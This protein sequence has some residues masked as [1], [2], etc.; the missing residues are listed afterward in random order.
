[1]TDERNSWISQ[2]VAEELLSEAVERAVLGAE[3]SDDSTT[4]VEM[5]A[6]K[7]D[8]VRSFKVLKGSNLPSFFAQEA[9]SDTAE[10]PG[11]REP[12]LESADNAV[13]SQVVEDHVVRDRHQEAKHRV[14]G[15]LRDK[16]VASTKGVREV[17]VKLDL[18]YEEYL[19]SRSELLWLK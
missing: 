1:M 9:V 7:V 12:V 18:G 17:Q 16:A 6:A 14:G 11:D 13:K 3:C 4:V 19:K 10:E 5:L 15:L 8:Q 2:I